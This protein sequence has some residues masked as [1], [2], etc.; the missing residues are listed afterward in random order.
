M[1]QLAQKISRARI[2]G[3]NISLAKA[4]ECLENPYWGWHLVSQFDVASL[5]RHNGFQH[6]WR[7]DFSKRCGKG[8][9][10][11]ASGLAVGRGAF[12]YIIQL[13]E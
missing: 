13:L 7:K 8:P 6:R 5:C 4:L 1:I 10:G 2:C 11:K 3:K 12:A 9:T